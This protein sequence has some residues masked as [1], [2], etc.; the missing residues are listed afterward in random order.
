VA[1]HKC[2]KSNPYAVKQPLPLRIIGYNV[3]DSKWNSPNK[4]LFVD[5]A[6]G[7]EKTEE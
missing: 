7:C 1:E 3:E 4:V 6:I 2:K 5:K